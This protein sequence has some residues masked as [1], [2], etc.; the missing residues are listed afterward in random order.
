MLL[1]LNRSERREH[2]YWI[3]PYTIVR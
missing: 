3:I 1:K 2:A